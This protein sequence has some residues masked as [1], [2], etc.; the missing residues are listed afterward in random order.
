ME[1]E[2]FS[3]VLPVD[4]DGI[5]RFTN[6]S[7]EDFTAKWGGK[8][9]TFPAMKTSPMLI[10]DASPIEVQQIRKKFAKEFAIRE[11][12]QTKQAKQMTEKKGELN[13]I[14]QANTYSDSE[15][16]PFIQK[17]LEPLPM[18]YSLVQELPKE[19]MEK[20]LSRTPRGRLRTRVL[21]EGDSL[22]ADAKGALE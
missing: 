3:T 12:F 22:E 9:Y 6:Y 2:K 5:F 20:K 19:D 8:S 15:L 7:E 13:S 16:A 17:C 14:F 18:A 21:Q 1:R 4:F 11:W 10:M